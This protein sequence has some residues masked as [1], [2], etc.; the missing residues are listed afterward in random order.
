MVAFADFVVE[1]LA[2]AVD[3]LYGFLAEGDGHVVFKDFA[4]FLYGEAFR[5]D[6]M[7]HI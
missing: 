4:D 5:A 2:A 3:A 6:I 1:I 7:N